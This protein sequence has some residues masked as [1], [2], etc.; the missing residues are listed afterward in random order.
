M[1]IGNFLGLRSDKVCSG[2]DDGH[3]FV[4]DKDTGRLEGIWEGDGSI[5][6]GQSLGHS[7]SNADVL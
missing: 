6:N 1:S 3:F 5:V 7:G 4:W 2:S